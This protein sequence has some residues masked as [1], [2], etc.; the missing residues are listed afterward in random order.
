MHF[1]FSWGIYL[2]VSRGGVT[3]HR[4]ALPLS[5]DDKSWQHGTEN[6]NKPSSVSISYQRGICWAYCESAKQT[7]G[8][9]K[10]LM[11]MSLTM[12]QSQSKIAYS[13][14]FRKTLLFISV[15]WS[16]IYVQ[17]EWFGFPFSGILRG[18]RGTSFRFSY[19]LSRI[20]KMVIHSRSKF[21]FSISASLFQ[22][23]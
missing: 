19:V 3:S 7:Q 15:F 16:V 12:F 1:C 20:A 9:V 13:V 22:A 5:A 14:S 2:Q 18:L 10:I 8:L 4:Q 23:C 21:L 17:I 11:R 6:D